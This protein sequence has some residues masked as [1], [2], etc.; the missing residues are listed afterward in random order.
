M[1]P[2]ILGGISIRRQD[3]STSASKGQISWCT[4]WRA[5]LGLSPSSWL[6]SWST[7]GWVTVRLTVWSREGEKLSIPMTA[8]SNSSKGSKGNY[9]LL[10]LP[11]RRIGSSL[12][13]ISTKGENFLPPPVHPVNSRDLTSTAFFLGM[14]PTATGWTSLSKTLRCTSSDA[15]PSRPRRPPRPALASKD[16]P[17]SMLNPIT[18]PSSLR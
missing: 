17:P 13:K 6:T 4:A 14:S 5:S 3:T 15:S 12:L 10:P 8:S 7:G 1:N 18:S 16:T 2:L 9:P 11:S